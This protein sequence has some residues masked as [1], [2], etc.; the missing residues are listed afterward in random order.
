[1]STDPLIGDMLTDRYRIDSK[2]GEGGMGA[3]YKGEDILL[4]RTVAIKV[5]HSDLKANDE[6]VAR[7]F[8]EAKV[9]AKLRH[10]NTI[11]VFDFGEAKD[12]HN[13]IAMEFMTGEPLDEHM[14]AQQI[15]LPRVFEILEQVCLSLEEA[16]E[17]GIIHRDL[18]PDNI[19]IDTVGNRRLVKV[20]D[21]GIAKLM[22]G[23]ANLTQAGMVFG[24]PA[25]MSPEQAR[26]NPLDPRSDIYSL[27]CLLFFLLTGHQPYLGDN[28]MEV[29]VKHITDP[30]P[31]PN[32][33]SHFGRLPDEL[34]ALVRRLM[35]KD[36]DERP[37]SVE[38]VRRE[39]IQVARTLP[40]VRVDANS[41]TG[42]MVQVR[43]ERT[44]TTDHMP[45][46]GE[47]TKVTPGPQ[48][49]SLAAGD[50]MEMVVPGRSKAPIFVVLALLVIGGAVGLVF[51]L[52]SGGEEDSEPESDNGEVA[53]AT[54]P[55]ETEPP[56]T[57]PA[58]DGDAQPEASAMVANGGEDP[59]NAMQNASLHVRTGIVEA[60]LAAQEN[61]VT[62]SIVTQPAGATVVRGDTQ[63]ELGVTPI[64]F[65]T[66]NG[67][68]EVPLAFAMD[69]YQAHTMT[70]PRRTG[71]VQV[72]LQRERSA[73][74]GSS[75]SSSSSD[76]GTSSSSGNN[77]D[78]SSDSS[79]G[80]DSS[81]SDDNT[82]SGS[83]RPRFE[84]RDPVTIVND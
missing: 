37:S 47:V 16:H 28:P 40:D 29:A 68:E 33:D 64:S 76:R 45:N 50:S 18:K 9:V 12:G 20:I 35:A 77:D 66:S 63:V 5:L 72:T 75:S 14:Q 53:E 10:P 38:D 69:G 1:M 54:D 48:T 39:I 43:T 15:T 25:Y 51:A 4:G 6:G 58:E 74:T 34:V 61:T 22:S 49:G 78:S 11:Q 67:E 13:Y 41:R 26:G 27:G 46:Q 24:T 55:A 42:A 8:N 32:D 60:N 80:S 30:I 2:I 84:I 57:E 21:F 70:T 79:A 83:T 71:E 23:D 62:I 56:E 65:S 82:D 81:A 44:F 3:V 52:S 19:F 36:R 17:A 31:D 59:S 7:F 73:Y